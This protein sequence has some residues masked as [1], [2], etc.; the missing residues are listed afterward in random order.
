M[1]INECSRGTRVHCR[2]LQWLIVLLV[3][4]ALIIPHQAIALA[5]GNPESSSLVIWRTG[6]VHLEH[7]PPE[8]A[9]ESLKGDYEGLRITDNGS[10][11]T[12]GNGLSK[13]LDQ[14]RHQWTL[15]PGYSAPA[16]SLSRSDS[17]LE[18]QGENCVGETED[19]RDWPGLKRDTAYF[20][21]YQFLM[22]GL[23]YVLP[24]DVGKWR[25][26][27]LTGYDPDLW[28]H[29]V[30]HPVWDKDLW[31]I[32]YLN[33]PYWGATFYVRARERG[34]SQLEST[35]FSAF[36]SAGWEFGPE[37]IFEPPSYQDL[38]VTPAIGSMV[39]V[40]FEVLRDRIKAKGPEKKW[41]DEI[42]LVLTDP[43]G[44]LNKLTDRLL[45][46]N[47]SIASY[48]GICPQAVA[49]IHNPLPT[50]HQPI[51]RRPLAGLEVTVRW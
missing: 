19:T 12:P 32:N 24:E 17:F 27:R 5:A 48:R 42:A 50:A 49:D 21:G 46:V 45:G 31:W 51:C 28:I 38:I 9:D 11:M 40:C 16:F 29:N 7:V 35:L 3:M 34:F 15:I 4:W 37:A 20:F 25:K 13:S 23:I 33:H 36:L 41:Y 44:A 26:K 1:A 22:L 43:L 2:P 47:G 14:L 8:G 18:T 30:T 39:G 10:R 6:G